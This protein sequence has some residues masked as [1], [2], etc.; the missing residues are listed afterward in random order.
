MKKKI[1]IIIIVLLL[2]AVIV[3]L[4]SK[5]VF[6]KKTILGSKQEELPVDKNTVTYNG[7]LHTD[8]AQLKNEKNELIQLRGVSSHGIEWFPDCFKYEEM[9]ILKKDW[10]INVVRIA[11]YTDAGNTGF[12][13]N[14][15]FNMN[16]VCEI[17][18][19]AIKLDMYVIVDWHILSDNNPQIHQDKSAQFFDEIS[20]K[21]ADKPNVIYEICNEPN[22]STTWENNVK[23]YAEKIIPIIRNNSKNSLI[24]VGTPNWCLSINSAAKSPLN[25]DNIVYSFHFY[26]GSHGSEFRNTINDCIENNIPIFISECGLTD[27]SGNGALY[28]NE[29]EDWVKFI[30]EKNLSWIYWSF[31]NKAEGSAILTPDYNFSYLQDSN[32][33]SSNN[34]T[35]TSAEPQSVD[36]RGSVSFND[37]LSEAGKFVREIFK[38]Y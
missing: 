28:F 2:L 19:N 26:A 3:F 27:A 10:N 23:P 1:L 36:T 35:N 4:L 6:K 37:Y 15:D 29:F 18:D 30:N 25:Y 34:T 20:R 33:N 24:I 31:C 22:G 32:D 8:G 5:I 21:Y 12:V 11:M 16:K 38:R 13:H 9:E 17:V 14:P 7:W